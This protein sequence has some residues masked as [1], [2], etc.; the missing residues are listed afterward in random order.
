MKKAIN[1]I[2]KKFLL[3]KVIIKRH[4]LVSGVC[5]S[6]EFLAFSLLLNFLRVEILWAYVASFVLATSIGYVLH[7]FYTF[8]V[9]EIGRRSGLYFVIQATFILILGY[10]IFNIFVMASIHPLIAKPMQ[11]VATFSLNVIIGK[12]MTF[13]VKNA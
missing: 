1:Q 12:K 7:S 6:S 5:A 2:K 8:S 10:A 4:L 9:G 11:L 13:K 3:N